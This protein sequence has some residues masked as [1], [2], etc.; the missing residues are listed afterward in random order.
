M[1]DKTMNLNDM[2]DLSADQFLSDV[3][4]SHQ[5]ITVVDENGHT[6][7]ICPVGLESLPEL[8]GSIPANW[9]D[10]IYAQ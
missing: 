6:V 4:Q 1:A 9:K 10:C 8:E 2:K 3:I 5:S 7:E